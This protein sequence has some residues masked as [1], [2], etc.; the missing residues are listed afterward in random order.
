MFRIGNSIASAQY[1]DFPRAPP[2]NSIFPARNGYSKD[3]E[4]LILRHSPSPLYTRP[5]PTPRKTTEP[6]ETAE[7]LNQASSTAEAASAHIHEPRDTS[8]IILSAADAAVI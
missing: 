2:R 4:L 1:G 8:I 5:D 6:P 3:H 7:V